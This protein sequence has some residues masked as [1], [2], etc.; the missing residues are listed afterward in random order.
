[1][2]WRGNYDAWR[3]MASVYQ[4][5]TIITTQVLKLIVMVLLIVALLCKRGTNCRCQTLDSE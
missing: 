1:M 2:Q 4:L 3:A 5:Q